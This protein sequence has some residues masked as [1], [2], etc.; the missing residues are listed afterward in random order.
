MSL[1]RGTGCHEI[2]GLMAKAVHDGGD[3]LRNPYL[4]RVNGV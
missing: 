2:R 4:E 1:G 3:F